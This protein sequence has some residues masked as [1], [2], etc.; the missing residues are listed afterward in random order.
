MSPHGPALFVHGNPET[1][2]VWGPLLGE[3][4]REDAVCLS[5]PGF[6]APIPRGFEPTMTAHRDWLIA[7]L[8]AFRYPVDLVGHDWGG[9]HVFNV[10]MARPDLIRS[11][12]SDAGGLFDPGYE[13]HPLARIWQTPGDG[14]QLVQKM[15]TAP[16]EQRIAAMLDL[17]IA[18][19]VAERLAAGQDTQMGRAI[20][21]LYRSEEGPRWPRRPVTRARP[22][23]GLAWRSRRPATTPSAPSRAGAASPVWQAP[24][25]SYWRTS[26]TGGWCKTQG[27]AH[28]RSPS[29]GHGSPDSHR[30]VRQELRPDNARQ[31]REH[32]YSTQEDICLL[33][34]L[35]N[36]VWTL[37][38]PQ[39]RLVVRSL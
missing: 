5:P 24:R 36:E 39:S 9:G 11:W 6:G 29:S 33:Q 13:W 15:M 12:V 19:P 38:L 16:L 1:S 27:K 8:E 18:S 26:D 37:R 32:R 3:L 28:A 22:R 23:R 4:D 34:R 7:R 10:A 17:G 35:I 20:L 31:H 21:A 2:A 30:P 25:S 14:E